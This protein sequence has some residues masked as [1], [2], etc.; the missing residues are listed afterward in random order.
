MLV[1]ITREEFEKNMRELAIHGADKKQILE[2]RNKFERQFKKDQ[3]TGKESGLTLMKL[4]S[5]PGFKYGKK[6]NTKVIR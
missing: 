1:I 3:P 5:I 6:S 2:A 4:Q